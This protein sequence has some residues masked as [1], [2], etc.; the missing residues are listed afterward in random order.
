MPRDG[1]VAARTVRRR[2][3]N[4]LATRH[5]VNADVEKTAHDAAEQE[6]DGRPEMKRDEL[7]GRG[8]SHTCGVRNAGRGVRNAEAPTFP[9]AR[10]LVQ[11][12]GPVDRRRLCSQAWTFLSNARRITATGAVFSDQI[13]S[14]LAP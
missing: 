13:S 7:P 2:A 8:I 1:I 6:K 12:K 5:P 9:G 11:W 3:D 10:E 14:A 4:A